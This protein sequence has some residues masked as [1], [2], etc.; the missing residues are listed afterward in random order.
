MFTCN[1]FDHLYNNIVH[2]CQRIAFKIHVLL[3]CILYSHLR[4]YI[5]RLRCSLFHI[6]VQVSLSFSR[7]FTVYITSMRSFFFKHISLPHVFPFFFSF[8]SFNCT[9]DS[10]TMNRLYLLCINSNNS[11]NAPIAKYSLYILF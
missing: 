4:S 8:P 5:R 6:F 7:A 10:F 2:K 9:I 1:A 3:Q 11:R